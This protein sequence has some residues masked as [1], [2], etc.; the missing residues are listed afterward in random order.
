MLDE[1]LLAMNTA[2]YFS[3]ATL[4]ATVCRFLEYYAANSLTAAT[5]S[6]VLTACDRQQ[7]KSSLKECATWASDHPEFDR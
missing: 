3:S 5:I 6:R 1:A 7:P 4:M 2:D